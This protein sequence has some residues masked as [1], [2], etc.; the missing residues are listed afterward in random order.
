[1][2][3]EIQRRRLDLFL[4]FRGVHELYFGSGM[5][6]ASCPGWGC[7]ESGARPWKKKIQDLGAA[8][9]M[10]GKFFWR[11]AL[12][13]ERQKKKWREERENVC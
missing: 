12:A 11:P 8:S 3:E 9:F 7:S 6:R 13:G 5:T 4:F 2:E 1:M 10:A